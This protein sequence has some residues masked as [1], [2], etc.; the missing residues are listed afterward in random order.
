MCDKVNKV[1]GPV[2]RFCSNDIQKHQTEAPSLLVAGKT[3]FG[4]RVQ[5]VVALD[6]YTREDCSGFINVSGFIIFN[7]IGIILKGIRIPNRLHT[8]SLVCLNLEPYSLHIIKKSSTRT[9]RLNI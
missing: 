3:A 6:V 9:G 1:L 8:F 7:G 2:K 4:I 5:P